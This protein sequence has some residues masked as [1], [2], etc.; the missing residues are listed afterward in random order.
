MARELITLGCFQKCRDGYIGAGEG[1]CREWQTV[2]V[3]PD[4]IKQDLRKTGFTDRFVS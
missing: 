4:N 3:F 2:A 1:G